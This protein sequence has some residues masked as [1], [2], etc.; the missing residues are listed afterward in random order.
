MVI[1]RYVSHNQRVSSSAGSMKTAYEQACELSRNGESLNMGKSLR[2]MEIYSWEN[3]RT[4]GGLS[5]KPCLIPRSYIVFF[6]WDPL[7]K[8]MQLNIIRLFW[9][10]NGENP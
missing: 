7:E 9:M 2:S 5:S 10:D 6:C 1:F 8:R 3:H 4:K